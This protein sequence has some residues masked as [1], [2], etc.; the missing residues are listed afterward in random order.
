MTNQTNI[1]FSLITILSCR[2]IIIIDIVIDTIWLNQKLHKI[3][4]KITKI[5]DGTDEI[6]KEGEFEVPC[7]S[8]NKSLS[9]AG[10]Y[11]CNPN[12]ST[13]LEKWEGPNFGI[14]SF[15]NIGFAML[16]V[17]QCITMEGWT[18]ILYWVRNAVCLIAMASKKKASKLTFIRKLKRIKM[19]FSAFC[20]VKRNTH[21]E[22][23]CMWMKVLVCIRAFV[24]HTIS[25]AGLFSSATQF[26]VKLIEYSRRLFDHSLLA[27]VRRRHNRMQHSTPHTSYM[28][29]AHT[30]YIIKR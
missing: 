27:R 17:F 7:N 18:A 11:S 20:F 25:D 16:T 19:Q 30:V 13:C 24:S 15:D 9:P 10:A 23:R 1:F 26:A 6:V 8:D 29:V 5:H 21:C 12:V 2:R 3:N 4:R 14:T 28:H 22:Q